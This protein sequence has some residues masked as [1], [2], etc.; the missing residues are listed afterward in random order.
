M[1]VCPDIF[2]VRMTLSLLYCL[3]PRLCA[4][5]GGHCI[6]G[7]A[8]RAQ[9]FARLGRSGREA[10]TAQ[11]PVGGEFARIFRRGV[12]ARRKG[13]GRHLHEAGAR[14]GLE[15]TQQLLF[16]RRDEARNG[17]RPASRLSQDSLD[18]GGVFFGGLFHRE[19][20]VHEE[21]RGKQQGIAHGVPAARRVE[22]GVLE[23]GEAG[24]ALGV[25]SLPD[26]ARGVEPDVAADGFE[27]ARIE[28]EFDIGRAL[29]EGRNGRG[30]RPRTPAGEV[31]PERD[32]TR[33]GASLRNGAGEVGGNRGFGGKAEA[34]APG[35]AAM[36]GDWGFGGAA[37]VRSA[38]RPRRFHG[39]EQA[40]GRPE[41]VEAAI[42]FVVGDEQEVK[43]VGHD[44]E[45]GNRCRL[46]GAVRGHERGLQQFAERQQR[47]PLF[48][49]DEP[50]KNG[51]AAFD[52]YCDEEE[53]QTM[54]G[55]V[56]FHGNSIENVRRNCN[57]PL[58]KAGRRPPHF[59]VLKG[60]LKMAPRDLCSCNTSYRQGRDLCHSELTHK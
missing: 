53:L 52:A 54:M 3:V 46:K 45:I 5:R 55:E 36:G 33:I 43:V 2:M 28:R 60:C 41:R 27:L 56:E 30:L 29:E 22:D 17:N 15:A 47:G 34:C 16:A 14:F 39:V 44:D 20:H 25:V 48:F 24:E 23:V 7:E 1:L 42:L 51:A 37:P 26:S 31:A 57:T 58:K 13:E 38:F 9:A 49:I 21:G 59:A 6:H 18:F 11:E 50:R 19:A 40:M 35:V 10:G 8:S 32:R 4:E 12:V